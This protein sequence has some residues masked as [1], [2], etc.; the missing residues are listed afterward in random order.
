[1][2]FE[3]VFC[4]LYIFTFIYKILFEMFVIC[5]L[6]INGLIS[7]QDQ[8]IN[9]MRYNKIDILLIQEH[10]IRD[11][12]TLSNNLNEFCHVSLNPAICS[13]GGTAILIDRKL[14]FSIL[15]VEKSADSR[16]LSMKL[17]IYDQFFHLVNVYAHSGNKK[18]LEREELFSN[19]LIYY[20]RNRSED[21]LV[22]RSLETCFFFAI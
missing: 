14:P 15:S 9:F 5:S 18:A 22:L 17:K 20:L 13:R 1:M 16:I 8:I 4:R 10:N 19:E 21:S 7:K 2:V 12:T 6:N 11:I 3:S